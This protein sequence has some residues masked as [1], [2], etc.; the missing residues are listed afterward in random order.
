MFAPADA[1]ADADAEMSNT[2]NGSNLNCPFKE[3]KVNLTDSAVAVGCTKIQIC[4]IQIIQIC[5]R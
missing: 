3:L 1:D 4:G 5:S 2:I